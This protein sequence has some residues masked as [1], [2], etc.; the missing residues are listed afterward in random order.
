VE[1]HAP[2]SLMIV[3]RDNGFRELVK[4]HLGVSVVVTGEACDGEEAVQMAKRLQPDVVLMEID[5]PI[6]DGVEAARLIKVDRP[7]TKVVLLSPAGEAD[8][9][10]GGGR[11]VEAA[12]LQADAVLPKDRVVSDIHS[13]ALD[14]HVWNRRL[15]R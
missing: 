2:F 14:A 7:Q 11:R 12:L 15:R 1:S 13:D 9:L 4:R 10:D 5:A 8:H 6:L 3:D